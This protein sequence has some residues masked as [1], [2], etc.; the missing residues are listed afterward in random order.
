M[1]R[2]QPVSLSDLLDDNEDFEVEDRRPETPASGADTSELYAKILA[3]AGP[4]LAQDP[5]LAAF[6]RA[7]LVA[8]RPFTGTRGL[9]G[10]VGFQ[11]LLAQTP[12]YADLAVE[13]LAERLF[14]RARSLIAEVLEE[15]AGMAAPEAVLKYLHWVL[16]QEK[17]F[18]T[19]FK[20][21][22]FEAALAREPSLRDLSEDDL[23]E[24]LRRESLQ[25][26]MRWLDGDD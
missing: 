14:Y 22:A 17:P 19:L 3:E 13:G 9:L 23:A 10:D 24:R 12:D 15:S 2:D 11:A 7:V 6:F 4:R 18:K 25:L 5:V 20:Q 16:I 8:D 21:K 1:L 26:L